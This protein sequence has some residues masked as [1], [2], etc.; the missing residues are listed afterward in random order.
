V[1]DFPK[2]KNTR[3]Q[4][5]DYS[6]NGMYF[7]TVC[8]KNRRNL[9]WDNPVGATCG[10][11]PL[12]AV[13]IL[14]EKEISRIGSIYDCV[15]VDKYVVMPNHVHMI[16]TI[17]TDEKCGRPQVAPTISRVMQKWKEDCYYAALDG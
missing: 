1:E 8:T 5:Y 6:G 3:L 2:R 14:V 10:R 15:T 4:N 7:V 9:L 11:P 16:L 17:Q 12:S 13:G